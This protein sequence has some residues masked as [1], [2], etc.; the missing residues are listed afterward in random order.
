M[1]G[2]IKLVPGQLNTEEKQLLAMFMAAAMPAIATRVQREEYLGPATL[3]IRASE[4]ALSAMEVYYDIVE[5]PHKQ[6][7]MRIP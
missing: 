6:P 3:A 7:F 5:E 1:P 4:Y 2:K